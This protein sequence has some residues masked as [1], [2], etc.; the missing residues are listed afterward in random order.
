MLE[1]KQSSDREAAFDYLAATIR[2]IRR[3]II[4]L[5]IVHAVHL[6]LDE[7]TNLRNNAQILG[8]RTP[9]QTL[10]K[11]DEDG[12]SRVYLALSSPLP[13]HDGQPEFANLL[14]DVPENPNRSN[15]PIH[16]SPF[17]EGS[18]TEV[19]DILD[20]WVQVLWTMRTSGIEAI[21][22]IDEVHIG[23]SSTGTE[24]A[25]LRTEQVQPPI[26]PKVW[27]PPP[28]YFSQKMIDGNERFMLNGKTPSSQTINEWIKKRKKDCENDKKGCKPVH[29]VYA[30]DSS[31][32]KY[33]PGWFL[34]E[35]VRQ[36]NPR[37]PRQD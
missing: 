35:H 30:K 23:I 33:V 12:T 22:G 32:A 25:V 8:I 31:H 26:A 2:S 11:T 10:Q 5:S 37:Q 14:F 19:L 36:W 21:E 24:A 34:D 16:W 1:S 29:V 20:R 4:D 6:F 7:E 13:P 9:W 15:A 28:D 3:A 17:K 27:D 18:Q